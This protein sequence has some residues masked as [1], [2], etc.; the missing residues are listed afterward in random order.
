MTEK[1][2]TSEARP[3]ERVYA[4]GELIEPAALDRLRQ[5]FS[6]LCGSEIAFCDAAGTRI[7]AAD[8]GAAPAGC[9]PCALSGRYFVP[10]TWKEHVLGRV[11]VLG[12]DPDGRTRQLAA[13]IAEVLAGL[14]RAEAHIR[15][16]VRELSAIYDLGG[17]FANSEDLDTILNIAAKRICEVMGVK[18]ASIRLLDPATQSLVIGGEHNLSER[19]LRKGPVKLEENPIDAA[20]FDGEIVYIED[21]R[22]DPR[23]R[24]REHARQEGLVSGLCCPLSYQIGRA[25][26]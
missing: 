4:L 2:G 25:H 1:T 23:V 7:D 3:V 22:T 12:G 21:A 14:C 5:A 18:A 19:Y 8:D 6:N 24:F 16:R 26:V 15:K 17:L 13:L 11:V 9:D 20:A 10:V